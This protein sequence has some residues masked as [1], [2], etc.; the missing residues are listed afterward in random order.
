[1]VCLGRVRGWGQGQQA[2]GT[3]SSWAVSGTNKTVWPCTEPCCPSQWAPCP[4]PETLSRP[5]CWLR[6]LG[7]GGA[8]LAPSPGWPLSGLAFFLHPLFCVFRACGPQE[9]LA[10]DLPE[11]HNLTSLWCA[12][13]PST[14][15][16]PSPASVW[17]ASSSP[18]PNPAVSSF[19]QEISIKTLP[20]PPHAL[21]V[22]P[23]T[24]TS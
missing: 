9:G 16:P 7:E 6:E 11:L 15:T 19:H 5:P 23:G 18:P 13:S 8:C 12:L 3:A 21:P 22:D 10:S 1:M 4:Q 24:D 20:S 14:W 17:W 2:R